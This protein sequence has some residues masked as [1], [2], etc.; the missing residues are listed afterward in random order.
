[1]SPTHGFRME[2]KPVVLFVYITGSIVGSSL[3]VLWRIL[4]ASL[5]MI[6]YS[7]VLDTI[8]Y[9]LVLV[10]PFYAGV[11][12]IVMSRYFKYVITENGIGAKNLAG[13]S[14]FVA[15]DSIAEL[16]PIK[17]GNLTFVR[18]ITEDNRS[19]MWLP[20]FVSDEQV[21]GGALLDCA[22][23]DSAIRGLVRTIYLAA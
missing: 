19:P 4:D 14:R 22:P 23:E 17:I 9:Y 8:G 3:I 6:P 10:A 2:F 20:L 21:F 15:W 16:R 7:V 12:G 11:C 1:M 18:L 5:Q 13:A